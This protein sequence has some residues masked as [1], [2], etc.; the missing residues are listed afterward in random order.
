VDAVCH[1]GVGFWLW[2][3]QR[4]VPCD[5]IATGLAD[6]LAR[7]SPLSRVI[8]GLRSG[9]GSNAQC[10]QH[11]NTDPDNQHRKRNGIIIEPVP[12]LYAHD[13]KSIPK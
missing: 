13:A 10:N 6:A 3:P 5:G 8:S 2:L 4:A 9:A 12:A 1:R 7:H 11:N